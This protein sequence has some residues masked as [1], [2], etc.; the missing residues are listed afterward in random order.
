MKR[1]NCFDDIIFMKRKILA[2]AVFQPDTFSQRLKT[3]FIA[4]GVNFTKL[5]VPSIG[6]QDSTKKFRSISPTILKFQAK[7]VSCLP[8]T[9]YHEMFFISF[10]RL[11][12]EEMNPRGQFFQSFG[13]K[14]KCASTQHLAQKMPFR[15]T[16][17]ITTNSIKSELEFMPIF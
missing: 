7:F 13:A 15:W 3:F 17:R 4:P 5:C 2:T 16:N 9:V 1:K 14:C 11:N 8:N 10:V 12:V 6:A